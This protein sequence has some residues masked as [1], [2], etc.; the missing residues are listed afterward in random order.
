MKKILRYLRSSLGYLYVCFKWVILAALVGCVVG[1]FGAM[2]GLAL[3]KATAL[4]TA[5][6]RLIYLLPLGGLVI[7]FLYQHFDPD[8]GGSTNQIFVA[9]R[10]HKP[11]SLRTAPLI[12]V[13]TVITHL[14]G[15]SSGRE[16]AAP[17][18][19]TV[20]TLEV[21]DV[22]SMQYAALLPCLLSA[23]IGVWISSGMGLA[24]TA[25]AVADYAAPTPG[26]LI[27]VLLLGLLLAALSIAFC[28]VI[29]AAPKLYKKLFPNAYLRVVVGGALIIALTTLLG[30]TDYNGAGANVIA[31]AIAGQA[32]PYAFLLKMLFTSITLGAGFKGGEIVPIFFT[33]ATFGCA[34]APLLGLAPGLGAALG[35]VALFCGC[36][37]SPLASIC[38]AIEVFGGQNIELFALACAVSYMMSSYF[39]LY[40]EQ[41]F[42]HSKLRV[43]GVQRVHGKWSETD[44]DAEN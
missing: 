26:N 19:A 18:A 44:S 32:V 2:F 24:P 31:A 3:N 38:L 17:L 12:F 42:L 41:H 16:G 21:V 40:R 33:G 34:V 9:V 8:G 36:T 22:G 30:T 27:R 25:F 11:L 28:E 7:V 13:T 14:F 6:P 35:M 37:N 5:D 39:S 1:P 10:E 15:G 4:R 43:V 20:F 29:H 23:L